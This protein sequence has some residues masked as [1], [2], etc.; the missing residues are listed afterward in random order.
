LA[1]DCWTCSS[2][3]EIIALQATLYEIVCDSS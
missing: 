1:A 2:L 3:K